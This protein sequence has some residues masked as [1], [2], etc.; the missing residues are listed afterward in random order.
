MR[1]VTNQA[2]PCL[3]R[4]V[5]IFLLVDILQFL[6][7]ALLANQNIT[8]ARLVLERCAINIMTI[9]ALENTGGAMHVVLVE[10]AGMAAG[11]GIVAWPRVGV[12]S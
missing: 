9:E 2:H 11:A 1:V 5:Q 4:A 3:Q 7:M 6:G 10:H 8:A 12:S